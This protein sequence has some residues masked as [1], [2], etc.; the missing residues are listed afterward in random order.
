MWMLLMG[1]NLFFVQNAIEYKTQITN[2]WTFVGIRK[3]IYRLIISEGNILKQGGIIII[4]LSYNGLMFTVPDFY[5]SEI[6]NSGSYSGRYRL[7]FLLRTFFSRRFYNSC[8]LF[9]VNNLFTSNGHLF[10]GTIQSYYNA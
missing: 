8:Q 10:T 1:Y 3:C 4:I 7:G 5:Y 6:L 2:F 9:S